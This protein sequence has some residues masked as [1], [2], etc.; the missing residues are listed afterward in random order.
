M[1]R[2]TCIIADHQSSETLQVR[3]WVT[4]EGRKLQ[5]KVRELAVDKGKGG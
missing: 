1:T 2:E 5:L 3:I 4:S